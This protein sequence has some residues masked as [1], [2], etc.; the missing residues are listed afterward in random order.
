MV[1]EFRSHPLKS[2]YLTFELTTTLLFRLPSWV[3]GN[4]PRTLRP[5][6]SWSLKKSVLIK[7]VDRFH[8]V[9]GRTDTL[10]FFGD[11]Q[12]VKEGPDVK[13]VWVEPTP[14]LMNTEIRKWAS[15][16][17]VVPATI[18][19]YWIDKENT[20]TGIGAPPGPGEKVIYSLHGGAYIRV[21]ASP[22]D[23]AA[24]IGRGLLEHCT[25]VHRVFAIEYRLSKH[26]P[27]E[28][29]HPFPAAL[30]DA[31]AGYVY[32]TDTVGF[33]PENIIIE[34]DSAGGNLALALVR[35]LVENAG[36]IKGL[37]VPPEALLLLSPWVD[38]SD[39]A[40]PPGSRANFNMASDYIGPPEGPIALY[41]RRAFFGPLAHVPNG[42]LNPYIAPG[43]ADMRMPRVSFEGFPRTMIVA[44]E[45]EMLVDQINILV[46]RMRRDLGEK[47]LYYEARDAV[48]DFIAL[49]FCEPERT[50]AL[51]AISDWL[52]E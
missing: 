2:L 45:A 40:V 49:P 8:L 48:H 46:R 43:C 22:H 27:D 30:L 1:H 12:T 44:G 5:R 35:Y 6:Q 26:L 9:L 18:P 37:P 47:V 32:L 11:H 16:A 51:A 14:H 3:L 39:I 19:G 41:A 24:N 17:E 33:A 25:D 13:H 38:P 21:S 42:L 34:G 7:V 15:A 31:L 10:L 36:L 4:L 23:I 28:P 50:L 29:R 52:G 20:S